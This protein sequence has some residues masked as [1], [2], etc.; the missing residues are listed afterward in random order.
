[1]MSLLRRSVAG[2]LLL[3]GGT[4]LAHGQDYSTAARVGLP[5]ESEQARNRL[6]TIDRLLEPAISARSAGSS[7]AQLALLRSPLEGPFTLAPAL[8]DRSPAVWEQAAQAYYDLLNDAGEAL[9][10]LPAEAGGLST[11]RTSVQLRRLCH[12]RLAGLPAAAL[13][14]YRQRVRSEADRLLMLGLEEPRRGS[15]AANR[16]RAVLQ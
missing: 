7:I 13:A 14:A 8:A 16:G 15:A 12:M 10:A 4:A 11:A 5:A 3:L 6:R 1:M 9:V 2:L